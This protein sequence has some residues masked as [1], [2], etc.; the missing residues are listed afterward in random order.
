MLLVA[1]R[2]LGLSLTALNLTKAMSTNTPNETV[3][4]IFNTISAF[5]EWRNNAR[6]LRKSV[7]F[8]PTMGALHPGHLALGTTPAV[9]LDSGIPNEEEIK[10]NDPSKPTI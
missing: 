1:R 4:P 3:I 7:G 6:N 2:G 9:P 10:R 5:R 8:V